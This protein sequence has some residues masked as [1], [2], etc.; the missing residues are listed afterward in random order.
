MKILLMCL[1][2]VLW[3]AGAY[4]CLLVDGGRAAAA[5]VLGADATEPEK[6]AARE[7][8]SYV[9]KISGARLDIVPEPSKELNNVFV[10]QTEL[11]RKQIPE[12]DW[13]SLKRD[14]ILV[15]SGKK[16][17]ILAGD[18]PAGTLYAVYD[19]L[20]KDLGVRFWAPGD[21][22]VPSKK[23]I[24]ASADRVYVPPFYLREDFFKL[25]MH[26]EQFKARHKLNGRT[27]LATS[28][29]SPE[30]GG[31]YDLI[32]GG[33]TFWLF[34]NPSEYFADHPEWYS[35][36]NGK[37]FS[38]YGQLCLSN[39]ECVEMLTQKVLEELRRHPDPRMISV[40]QTDN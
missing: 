27:N 14:G 13:D 5:I 7:L 15:R 8:Q 23:Y 30:W 21:E 10:G 4:A 37:R 39:D 29:I 36:I 31:C 17:L 22:Y 18:R 20:E 35:L 2:L 25:Y 3:S 26:D 38:G 40:T 12:F 32:G 9:E 24:T 6:N 11:T 1:V 33:H 16:T 19:F 34:M 28:P